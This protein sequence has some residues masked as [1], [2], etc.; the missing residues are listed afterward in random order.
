M[1]TSRLTKV[2]DGNRVALELEIRSG[3]SGEIGD[4]F[5]CRDGIGGELNEMH[6]C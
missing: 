2:G 6:Q 3:A 4:E 5:V 1:C